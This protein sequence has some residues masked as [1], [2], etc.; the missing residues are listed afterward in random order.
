M[1]KG[2][3]LVAFRLDIADITWE[4]KKSQTKEDFMSRGIW[5]P[6][7]VPQGKERVLLVLNES[8]RFLVKSDDGTGEDDLVIGKDPI[9]EEDEDGSFHIRFQR[10]Q[11]RGGYKEDRIS[12]EVITF[13]LSAPSLQTYLK[14]RRGYSLH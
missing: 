14:E 6:M 10:L 3:F 9:L 5:Q 13:G 4:Y 7:V 1:L 12:T 8:V 11:V 2:G